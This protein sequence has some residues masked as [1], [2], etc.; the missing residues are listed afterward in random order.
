[1]NKLVL[2]IILSFFFVN[3][4][5]SYAYIG[6]GMGG[7]VIAVTLG[8]IAAIFLALFGILYYPIKRALKM[9]RD[10]KIALQKSSGES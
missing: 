4:L 2:L 9:R 5:P 10:K 6:P 1:M 3:A 8:F 7:G